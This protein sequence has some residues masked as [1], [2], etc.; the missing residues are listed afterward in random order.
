VHGAWRDRGA[1]RL[2]DCRRTWR[3]VMIGVQ[4]HD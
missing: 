4:R 1:R 2:R 3:H